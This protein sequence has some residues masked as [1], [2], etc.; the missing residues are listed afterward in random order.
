MKSKSRFSR[1]TARLTTTSAV[2]GSLTICAMPEHTMRLL[3]LRRIALPSPSHHTSSIH[4]LR[5]HHSKKNALCLISV[6]RSRFATA[7]QRTL[8]VRPRR[9][10]THLLLTS[11]FH[12]FHHSADS[13]AA[14]AASI[15]M[16]HRERG[17]ILRNKK[18]RTRPP[19]LSNSLILGR[20]KRSVRVMLRAASTLA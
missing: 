2:A 17:Y 8:R 13:A 16:F 19:P 12:L 20:V 15:S 10:Q 4:H 7:L 14:A 9:T 18:V 1:T 5:Q 3:F 11:H 6:G